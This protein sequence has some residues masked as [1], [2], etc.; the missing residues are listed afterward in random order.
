[1]NTLLCLATFALASAQSVYL[2]LESDDT[3]FDGKYIHGM[4]FGAGLNAAIVEDEPE[5]FKQNTTANT[6]YQIV[7]DN[8]N[9][10]LHQEFDQLIFEAGS[11]LDNEAHVSGNILTYHDSDSFF[12]AC[13]SLPYDPSGYV[14]NNESHHGVA[15][16]EGSPPSNCTNVK[17]HVL[18][19]P[20][21]IYD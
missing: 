1:M 9:Y 4:H 20:P 7:G 17:I 10:T 6:V 8:L 13:E 5:Y 15:I 2:E 19:A 16:Y 11:P 21:E 14:A 3:K 18:Y 12:Y